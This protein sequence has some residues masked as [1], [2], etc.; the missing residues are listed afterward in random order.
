MQSH[1]QPEPL[2]DVGGDDAEGDPEA[3]GDRRD[4]VHPL[5]GLVVVLRRHLSRKKHHNSQSQTL[6]VFSRIG[7][8]LKMLAVC[9]LDSV[10][11][12]FPCFRE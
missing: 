2:D 5:P 7:K 9:L 12:T 10:N 4:E 8:K 6:F 1:L 11:K 3:V